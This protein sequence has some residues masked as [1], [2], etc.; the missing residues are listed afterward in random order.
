M[1]ELLDIVALIKLKSS[2]IMFPV[3]LARNSKLLFDV[4]VVIKL[5]SIKISPVVKLFACIVP[6]LTILPTVNVP[7]TVKLFVISTS[8]L[9][10]IMLPVPAACSSKSAFDDVVVITLSSIN[11]SSNW[12]APETSKSPVTVKL[13]VISKL[14]VCD[15]LPICVTVPVIPVSPCRSVVPFTVVSPV[16]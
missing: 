14:P 3:P 8:L 13:P 9:G 2:K 6:V 11:I 4:V 15:K 1:F 12:N 7:S 10:T 16:I 5:S